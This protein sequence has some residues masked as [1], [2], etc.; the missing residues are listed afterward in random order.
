MALSPSD[1]ITFSLKIVSADGDIAVFQKAKVQVQAS[2]DAFQKLDDANAGLFSPVNLK[3]NA[4]QGE[5][6]L[7]DGMQRSVITEQDIQDSGNLTLQNHF[8]P[9]DTSVVVPSLSATHNVWVKTKPFALTFAIGKTYV[10]TYPTIQKEGDIISSI[11]GYITSAASNLDIENTTGQH[12][13]TAVPPLPPTGSIETYDAVVTLKTDTVN[14]VNA[15]K[16]FLI[17][18][19]ATIVT[20]DK[21]VIIQAQNNAAINNINNVIIPALNTWLAYPDFNP[22][23]GG[24]N[25]NDFNTY[26]PALLAPTKL[27]S[28][29]LS[30]LQTALNNRS[31][32]ITT[33][34]PQIQAVLGG[35]SQDINTGEV[36]GTGLYMQRYGFLLLR[37]DRLTGSLSQLTSAKAAGGAQDSII[38]SL[39][40]NKQT[41]LSILPT[42]LLLASG[43]DTSDVQIQDASFLA[44]G[45]TVYVIAEGQNELQR[46]VKSINGTR[47]TLNDIVPAKYKTQNKLRLYKDLT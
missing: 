43:N 45:D 23:P 17:G 47:V 38:S 30:A 41:Y 3:V 29:Q 36:T 20:N 18:E 5:I 16:T 37:L 7:L 42:A 31:S 44:P 26:N 21:N 6:Q 11:L 32:F 9:N 35:I 22:V 12:V 34:I 1:R 15:L 40:Q 46:A 13:V 24:T 28:V 8:F 39:A 33:R 27:Y 19:V 25:P 10:E 2:V 14:A 4:Y